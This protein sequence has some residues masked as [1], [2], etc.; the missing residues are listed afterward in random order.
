MRS[1]N[2]S[3][4]PCLMRILFRAV[5][6]VR[7]NLPFQEHVSEGEVDAGF[8]NLFMK[9]AGDVRIDSLMSLSMKRCTVLSL[10]PS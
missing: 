7:L 3:M 9:L 8:R 2:A 4:S 5:N 1:S 10:S 6:A